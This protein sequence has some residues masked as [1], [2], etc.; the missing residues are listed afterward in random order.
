MLKFIH[1]QGLIW[2][3]GIKHPDFFKYNANEK[4][5]GSPRLSRSQNCTTDNLDEL[6]KKLEEL[7][8]PPITTLK[9]KANTI[10]FTDTTGFHARGYAKPGSER[11][12]L[13]NAFRIN[14]F[15]I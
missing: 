10:I 8:L 6:N 3:K 9:A 4:A 7:D 1:E 11:Y 15:I 13:R 2:D 12:S 14:P 5:M